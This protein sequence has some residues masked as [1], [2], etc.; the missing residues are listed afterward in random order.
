MLGDFTAE[1]L[2]S[3]PV[4]RPTGNEVTADAV[5]R[6]K[7]LAQPKRKV[8]IVVTPTGVYI[9][10]A[11]TMEHVKDAP[12]RDVSFVSLDS[13]DKKLFSYITNNRLLKLTFCHI[14]KVTKR[15][16]DIPVALN[17]AFRIASGQSEPLVE[18][19]Q[20]K[21]SKKEALAIANTQRRES[22]SQSASASAT[23]LPSS[24]SSSPTLSRKNSTGSMGWRRQ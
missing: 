16:Q 17:Q 7:E 3:V 14:F 18:G 22:T 5:V 24:A 4:K 15:A 8:H 11:K 13:K 9:V 21:L 19:L 2:G 1:Y 10:D 23:S 6:V 12:I 20:R